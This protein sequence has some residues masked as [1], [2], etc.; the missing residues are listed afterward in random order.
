MRFIDAPSPN[1]DARTAPPDMVLLH[2]TGMATGQEALARL[3]DPEAKVS[4]HYLIE[5]DGRVFAL[6][7]EERRAWHAGVSFWQ[8]MRN[9]NGVSI[10]VE[11]VNPGHDWGY[12][13]YPEVQIAALIDLLTGVRER[14]DVADGRIV[15]H[16]DVAPDRKIDPGELFPW[17]RLAKAGFG[18]WAEPPPAPGAPL[19]IGEESTAVFALQA[20][21]T[22]L[23]YDSAPSGRYDEATATIVSAFQRHWRPD[24][25]DGAA[26]GETRAR[27]MALLRAA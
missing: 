17:K 4:A 25:I 22:R 19:A 27:L 5:E 8:G 11:I 20:G 7:A 15:G 12:R 1:F 24:R 13:P 18:L 3:R 14:W 2:Y 21:L 16:S 10:G 23:G 6:V 9:L 26:D